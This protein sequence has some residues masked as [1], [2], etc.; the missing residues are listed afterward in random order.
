MSYIATEGMYMDQV[1]VHD[2]TE[3]QAHMVQAF[4]DFLRNQI[5]KQT[6]QTKH[7]AAP[8]SVWNL[9]VKSSLSRTD[10]YERI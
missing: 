9:G 5:R 4:V 7:A 1:D 6:E 8:F 10:I 2:L 3:E